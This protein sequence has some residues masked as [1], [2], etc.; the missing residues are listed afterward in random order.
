VKLKDLVPAASNTVNAT[1]I[2]LDK[3]APT[4]RPHPEGPA[5]AR[6]R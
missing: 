5:A 3:A 4:A 2:V 1:F 6:G